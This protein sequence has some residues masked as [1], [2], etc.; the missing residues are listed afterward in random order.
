MNGLH[1]STQ[2]LLAVPPYPPRVVSL[3]EI[4]AARRAAQI[5]P[6]AT[7]QVAPDGPWLPV[8]Q[9][10]AH[11][12][13]VVGA[14]PTRSLLVALVVVPPIWAVLHQVV[15]K[16]GT[17]FLLFIWAA[18]AA[19]AIAATSS[20]RL[21]TKTSKELLAEAR[22]RPWFWRTMIAT[23][24]ACTIAALGSGGLRAIRKSQ[25]E[26]TLSAST[27]DCEF[28]E[29]WEKLT[30]AE[31][32][33]LEPQWTGQAHAR[34]LG[35]E[36][37]RLKKAAEEYRKRCTEVAAHLQS[38]TFPAED[39]ALVVKGIPGG[40]NAYASGEEAAD[41]AARIADRSLE[42]KDLGG[43]KSLPCGPATRRVY[44]DAVASSAA[45]WGA[46]TRA[47]DVGDDVLD[48]LGAEPLEKGKTMPTPEVDLT[49]EAR[50][51]LLKNAEITAAKMKSPK[52][53][54]EAEVPVGLCILARR[55]GG[56]PA[57][58]CSAL[59]STVSRLKVAEQLAGKAAEAR[60]KAALANQQRCMRICD[61]KQ[62]KDELG[63]P[64]GDFDESLDCYERCEKTYPASGCE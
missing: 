59:A 52:T 62:P 18:G 56:K 36:E 42:P 47:T 29:R 15:L 51:A 50:T 14:P 32:D 1:P 49:D 27:S 2:V 31:L 8:D 54:S 24:C 58:A 48:A 45:A 57:P 35:C 25:A 13:I 39:R 23:V 7:V 60:C 4:A 30:A 53:S 38:R 33:T 37:S 55:L 34:R 40:D 10:L 61:A 5:P 46:L 16:A 6:T 41:L 12:G 26:K 9:V 21:R 64:A 28:V 17:V 63:M 19:L 44:L 20:A 3:N 22:V 11:A 43:M